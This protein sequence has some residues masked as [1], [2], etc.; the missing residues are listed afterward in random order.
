MPLS[1][2]TKKQYRAIGHNLKPIVTI[3]G[4]GITE[5]V[6]DELFRALRDHELIKIKVAIAERDV[7]KSVTGDIVEQ[8]GA[9]IVQEIGKT[10]LLFK[11]AGKP[12]PKLTNLRFL[13]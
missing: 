12:N 6:L 7:R 11:K 10:V 13:P 3:A 2:D 8:T 4:N 5:G 9:E 1:S